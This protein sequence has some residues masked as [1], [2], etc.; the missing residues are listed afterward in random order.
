MTLE[1]T[2]G[3]ESESTLPMDWVEETKEVICSV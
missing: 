3:S 1:S 2:I